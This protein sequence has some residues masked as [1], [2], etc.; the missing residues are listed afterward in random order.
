M[1]YIQEALER[2]Y[3]A[4]V[5]N[6]GLLAMVAWCVSIFGR[7]LFIDDDRPSLRLALTLGTAFGVAAALLMNLPVELEPGIFGDARGAPILMS[8]IVGGPIAAAITVAMAGA[9]RLLLGGSGAFS[10]MLYVIAFGILGCVWRSMARRHGHTSIEIPGLLCLASLATAATAPLVLM[11]PESKQFAV[12]T[13][14]WPQLWVANML[15]VTI[16]GTLIQREWARQKA[17]RELQE[18]RVRAER[19][20]D[21]KSKFLAAMSHEIR[22]PL[23]GILGILQLVLQRPLQDDLHRDLKTAQDSGFFLL[24]LINQVLDFA[25]IEAGKVAVS[26][27]DFL[28]EQLGDGLCSMFCYQAEAKGLALR[29]RPQGDVETPVSGD[30]EHIR[31]ILFNLLGNA[32][33][34]TRSGS[35]ELRGGLAPRDEGYLLTFV[36]A[37]TG[38]GIPDDELDEI[39]MEFH[40]SGAGRDVG[41]TGLGL[42]IARELSRALGGELTLESSLGVGTTFTLTVP[43]EAASRPRDVARKP[44][45][46]RAAAPLRVLVAED[47]AVNQMVVR[48]M[49]EGQGHHVTIAPDGQ[50]AV[51][52]LTRDPRGFDAVLMDV[53]MPVMDGIQAAR[54]IRR[55]TSRAGQLP[56]IALTANAFEEQKQEYLAAGMTDVLIKPL[57]LD[58]LATKL[59]N[60]DLQPAA[61]SPVDQLRRNGEIGDG[62]SQAA[63]APEPDG[64]YLDEA[65]FGTLTDIMEPNE[66]AGLFANTQVHAFDLLERLRD[67]EP[68]QRRSLSHELRGMLANVG[69]QK[70][71]EIAY[72]VEHPTAESR[73]RHELIAELERVVESSVE[74]ARVRCRAGEDL[75]TSP[76]GS[77]S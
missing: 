38:P 49:L 15:G 2:G 22:T 56:I 8:G 64:H 41:G 40:Q 10:G 28:P 52:L 7:H 20:A 1:E 68:D 46:L 47:N 54:T 23:N 67:A 27:E 42:S 26:R 71:A 60:L 69:F 50:Q 77:A 36:V 70:A 37:D 35:V 24:T 72:E 43:V 59:A 18:Q 19:A 25:R 21:A 33:K 53:Q 63:S 31:Q 51:D 48:G 6:I 32:I 12:L 74:A 30:Y 5:A 9:M 58:Q 76:E 45:A 29:W 55:M 17:E 13:R 16:L 3:V 39:F 4:L 61:S 66:L 14:L 62:S 73:D 65:V 11:L 44:T 34:F 75:P 57:R